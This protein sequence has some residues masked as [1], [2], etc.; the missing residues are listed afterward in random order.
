[1]IRSP[2]GTKDILPDEINDWQN[3]EDVFRRITKLFGYKE[4]RTPIFES[5]DVF[6]RSIGESSDIVNKEMY[7]FEDRGGN[8]I[9]LRP[10]MTAALVRACIQNSLANR[11]SL[12]K[13]WYF[14]P[15]FRYERP[16][17]GRFRQFHQFGAECLSA[18]T[19]ES[20]AEVV[21]LGIS[22]IKELGINDYTLLINTLGSNESRQVYREQLTTYLKKYESDLSEDSQR[23]L[24]TNPLRILDSKSEKDQEIISDAPTLGESLDDESKGRF[25]KVL[26]IL[27]EL[28]I[29][30]SISDK[31]VRGLDYYSHT[32]F[33]FQ[34]NEL[35]AQDSFGGGGRYDGLF[36]QLGGK[37]TP[38]VGFAFGVERLLLILESIGKSQESDNPYDIYIITGDKKY[39]GFSFKVAN[40]LRSKNLKVY[41]DLMDKSFKSQFK[42]SNK[43]NCKYTLIIAENEI[44]NNM[45]ALKNMKT[46]E[47]EEYSLEAL[48]DIK[49]II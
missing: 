10:E 38:S 34:S 40:I 17:K 48:S 1:M 4:I 22:I 3:I 37:H 6:S 5:T 11:G 21:N 42:E 26:E 16:Q 29:S 28:D 33:E 39:S 13:L 19:P 41:V 15:F 25:D 23:R 45:F 46:G 18:S 20:D 43:L 35:G 44:K 24:T 12:E 8:L 27:T 49:E 30:F 2:R 32:V 9:T 7:T 31:L 47:Q 14:G 36:E